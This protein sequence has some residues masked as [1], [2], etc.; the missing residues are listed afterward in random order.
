MWVRIRE[1]TLKATKSDYKGLPAEYTKGEMEAAYAKNPNL[2]R[3][4]KRVSV[5]FELIESYRADDGKPRKPRQRSRYLAAIDKKLV[6]GDGEVM[7]RRR[8]FWNGLMRRL[9]SYKVTREDAEKVIAS[10]EK[11]VPR[12]TPEQVEAEVAEHRRALRSGY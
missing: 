4:N 7:I 9:K 8:L 10:V 12:P 3:V 1:K 11:V 5:V 6:I 2:V